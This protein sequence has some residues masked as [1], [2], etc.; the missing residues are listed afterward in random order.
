ME[1]NTAEHPDPER[2]IESLRVD[3]RDGSKK[4]GKIK[5]VPPSW[6]TLDIYIKCLTNL[7]QQQRADPC[8]PTM[9]LQAYPSP[10]KYFGA[11]FDV[12]R[13][14]VFRE[15]AGKDIGS[16]SG[17]RRHLIFAL[18]AF[19]SS[20]GES[21]RIAKPPDLF[22][23]E[24]TDPVGGG[25]F[26]PGVVLFMLRGKTNKSGRPNYGV[27]PEKLASLANNSWLE[28]SLVSVNCKNDGICNSGQYLAHR[29][30]MVQANIEE[31]K[32]VTHRG[33][34]HGSEF[35]QACGASV[36]AIAQHGNWA[37]N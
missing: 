27:I 7:Y 3:P 15:K 5:L 8:Y 18:P 4:R 10:R 32:K 11:T 12:Y 2:G 35:T 31:N 37:F 25:Q 26:T 22:S 14:C 30:I 16:V 24:V 13:N 34:V 20:L 23:H 29:K 28:F 17:S 21:T 36:E 19:K 1:E 9:M 33:R 6:E